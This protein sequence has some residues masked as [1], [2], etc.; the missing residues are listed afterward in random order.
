[1]SKSTTKRP[2]NFGRLFFPGEPTIV[3]AEI[4]L[5][6]LG[7]HVGN[8]R[9]LVKKWKVYPEVEG[10]RARV[11]KSADLHDMGKPQRFSIQVQTTPKGAFK[12]YIY[13]FRGHRFLAESQDLWAQTLARGHHDFSVKD[14]CRDTY[15]LRKESPEYAKLLSQDPLA[16]AHE[17]Y[18]L[19]MCD[20]IEAELAC[21]VIGDEHQAESRTFMD[22]T[23]AKI[24]KSNYVLDPWPFEQESLELTFKYWT[25]KLDQSEKTQLENLRNKESDSKLGSALDKIVK[26]WW[27]SLVQ[28]PKVEKP[29]KILLKSLSSDLPE[30]YDIQSIYQDLAGFE[31]NPMQIEMYKAIAE[32]EHPSVMLKGPTGAGKTESVLFPALAKGYRLILPLPAKSLLE[33]QKQRIEKY[34]IKF[35][36]LPENKN[37]EVSLVVDTGSQMKRWVYK[38]GEDIS[39]NLT[40]NLRRHLYKGDVILTTLDKFLYRYFSFGDKQKSFIFPLRINQA[41]TLICFDEAHSY[42]EIAFTNFRSL[43]QS[44]YEAG[45]SIVLM[46]ATMPPEQ[47]AHFDYLETIDYIADEQ[48]VVELLKFQQKHLKQ[49]YLGQRSLIWLDRLV[50]DSEFPETFQ[51]ELVKIILKEWFAKSNRRIL[52][53]VETVKDAAVIYQKIKESLKI[54]KHPSHPFLFLY[55]GRIA[56]Q[57]RAPLYQL[58]QQCDEQKKPY[59]LVTTSAIEVGCDLNAEILISQ[60]CPPES[61][62]QRAGRCNRRGDVEDA[63]VIVVGDMIPEFANTLN[64]E[65]WQKYQEALR[66]LTSFDSKVIAG[67]ITKSQQIDDYRVIELFSML[68]DYVYKAD[69][70]C[71]PIHEKGLVVTRSWTPSA[72][73]IYDDGTHADDFSKMPQISVPLDRLILKKDKA[74]GEV[75]NQYSATN[76]FERFYHQEQTRWC[77]R[78]LRHG[79]AYQKDIIIK[80]G[81]YGHEIE[82]GL[83]YNYDEEL[84]FVDLPGIFTKWRPVGFDEKLH[85]THSDKNFAVITYTKSLSR[86]IMQDA[87]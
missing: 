80:L 17:L 61:L 57:A 34:L 10:S 31:P 74:T 13:S 9:R 42:D 62:I 30:N 16:Y 1:M 28:H 72:T 47:A 24:D 41:K 79:S 56:S 22:F 15:S 2:F 58:I 26:N 53:V 38:N 25:K 86:T 83:T 54:T 36:V 5:Q 59:I 51:D 75:I 33:D 44:L 87:K 46:T 78:D 40:I 77:T 20:Q 50:R 6:P 43:V 60:I 3:P 29:L 11:L 21:R 64:S 55:H 48:N 18:I 81:P 12:Q 71:Q 45:R 52:V 39:K 65:G 85:C 23:V 66:S 19:E 76:V 37:R 14:I 32:I 8:V 69:L 27:H 49:K 67:C 70:T 68:H 82:A 4:R 35:S 84:G 7:D 73:L 63:K